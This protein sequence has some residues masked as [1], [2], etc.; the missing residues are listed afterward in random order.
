MT[1]IEQFLSNP[2]V[3]V[4]FLA[5]ILGVTTCLLLKS[6]PKDTMYVDEAALSSL[7]SRLI[8]ERVVRSIV[9][10]RCSV[11]DSMEKAACFAGKVEA[12]IGHTFQACEAFPKEGLATV[13]AVRHMQCV[14]EIIHEHGKAAL[15]GTVAN[16]LRDKYRIN[17]TC[18]VREGK[19][20]EW[21]LLGDAFQ[22]NQ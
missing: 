10:L 12:P 11:L 16:T 9:L 6:R 3:L 21:K 15:A 4:G 7:E 17:P 14:V 19:V 2:A 20:T 8:V 22:Q 18:N 1:N 5:T 13:V